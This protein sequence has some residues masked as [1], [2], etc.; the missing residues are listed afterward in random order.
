MDLTTE[1]L[2]LRDFLESDLQRLFAIESDPVVVRYQ[3]YAPKTAEE[4]RAYIARDLGAREDR[5]CFDLAVTQKDSGLLI[6]RLGLNVIEPERQIGELWFVLDRALWGHGLMPE[7]A[8]RIVDFGFREKLLRRVFLE[9]DP[10]NRGAARLAEKLGMMREGHLR[11]HGLYKGE[12]C[13]S[14]VYGVL[15]REWR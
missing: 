5:T 3:S 15:A 6:G 10:R 14:L 2:R 1:R 8:R 4:C 13:D 11:E 9:C 12:W 7:A